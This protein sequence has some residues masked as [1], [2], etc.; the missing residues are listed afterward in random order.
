MLFPKTIDNNYRGQWLALPFLAVAV[1]SK[2][3]MSINTIFNTRVVI[4]QADKITLNHYGP[5]AVPLIIY[6][7]RA[8]AVGHLL[9]ALLVVLAMVRYRAMIPLVAL[10]LLAEQLGRKLIRHLTSLP[11][12]QQDWT[13]LGLLFTQAIL[14]AL[15]IA[16]VLSLWPRAKA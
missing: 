1:L 12:V 10:L 2:M 8:W 6:M 11:G 5:D 16:F 4:E 13:S 9:L 3:A 14:V 15:V 7:F